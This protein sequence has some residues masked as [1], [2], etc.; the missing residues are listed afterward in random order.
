MSHRYPRV[1]VTCARRAATA[2]AKRGPRHG[3]ALLG[4]AV[5]GALVGLGALARAGAA[6]PPAAPSPVNGALAFSDGGAGGRDLY[7]V[8][9]DGTGRVPLVSIAAGREAQPAWSPDGRLVAFSTELPGG[10]WAIGHV[11]QPGGAIRLVTNGPGD[12]EP[13]WRHD[14]QLIAFSSF[15][16]AVTQV[17]R[18]TLAVVRPDGT[19]SRPSWSARTPPAASSTSPTRPGA[20]PA[21]CSPTPVG[22]TS[23]RPGRRTGGAWPSPPGRTGPGRRPRMSS[24]VSGCTT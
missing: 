8:Q 11:E 16:P 15:Y 3:P 13:D 22:T 24:T 5:A 9:P 2:W 18:S 23:T 10:M 21:A 19:G 20:T 7:T 6:A 14:G 12:L 17:E 4:L 1:P